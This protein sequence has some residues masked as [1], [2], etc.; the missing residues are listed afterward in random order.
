MCSPTL[1]STVNDSK[2]GRKLEKEGE[3][4]E[5]KCGESEFSHFISLELIYLFVVR[6]LLNPQG[7]F[8]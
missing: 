2:G 5:G 6:I 3:I 4:R 7:N 1:L 8:V